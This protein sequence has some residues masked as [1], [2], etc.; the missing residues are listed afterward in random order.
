MPNYLAR[1]TYTGHGTVY[2]NAD[3]LEEARE[4]FANYEFD[5]DEND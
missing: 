1:A 2:V 4:K 5:D 3:S